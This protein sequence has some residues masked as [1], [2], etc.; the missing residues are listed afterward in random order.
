MKSSTWD[1]PSWVIRPSACK[2][3]HHD[4]NR[5]DEDGLPIGACKR[6]NRTRAICDI[7]VN[8][9][10]DDIAEQYAKSEKVKPSKARL[11]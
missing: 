3:A 10:A 1:I 4:E 11:S 2:F 7:S 8:E 5:F 9:T 6:I